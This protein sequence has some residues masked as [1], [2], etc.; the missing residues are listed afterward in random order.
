MVIEGGFD[1]WLS[2]E[3]GLGAGADEAE[4]LVVAHPQGGVPHANEGSFLEVVRAVVAGLLI[5]GDLRNSYGHHSPSL[6]LLH[7]EAGAK[8]RLHLGGQAAEVLRKLAGI[9]HAHDLEAGVLV[10]T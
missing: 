10:Q 2:I 9:A 5:K 6:Y 4:N 7:R 1:K 3:F 8:R